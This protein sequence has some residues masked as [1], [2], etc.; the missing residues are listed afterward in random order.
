MHKHCWK[1]RLKIRKLT[2]FKGCVLNA[3]LLLYKAAKFYRHLFGGEHKLPIPP[4]HPHPPP[5]PKT[6][7]YKI[8]LCRAISLLLSNKSHSHLASKVHTV[9]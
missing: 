9:C 2:K 8:R 3:R 5:P 1:E 4:P 6:S 7:T